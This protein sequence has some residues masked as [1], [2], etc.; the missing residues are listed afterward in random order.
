MNSIECN[1]GRVIVGKILPDEDIIDAIKE[2]VLKHDI[3]SGLVNVIGALKKT[4]IGYFDIEIK[5]YKF[6]TL[7]EDVELISCMGNVSYDHAGPI[8]HLHV[9]LGKNDFNV[10]GGHLSQPS[11]VSIT[12]EVLIYEINHK[13]TRSTDPMFGLS[14]LNL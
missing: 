1:I 12:A 13:L 3:K 11:I 8:V 10:I 5:N 9:S 6:K 4:T 2:M 14:L 7:D